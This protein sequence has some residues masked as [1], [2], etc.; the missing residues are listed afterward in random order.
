MRCTNIL[1]NNIRLNWTNHQHSTSI[2]ENDRH[3]DSGSAIPTILCPL[4][5]IQGRDMANSVLD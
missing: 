5:S 3:Y 1:V 2:Q 4:D